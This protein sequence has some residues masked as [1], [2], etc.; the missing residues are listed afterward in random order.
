M[1]GRLSVGGLLVMGAAIRSGMSEQFRDPSL[2][3][4]HMVWTITS[5]AVAY[6]LA[7]ELHRA[8]EDHQGAFRAYEQKLRSF[9]A[10]KQASASRFAAFFAPRTELQLLFRNLATRLLAVPLV[11][12]AM[13]GRQ[14]NDN[15]KLPDYAMP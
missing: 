13:M 9:V 15:I 3:L 10:D 7:G 11:G 5:G 2:T 14:V 6:V 4:P 1:V 8:G 12:P